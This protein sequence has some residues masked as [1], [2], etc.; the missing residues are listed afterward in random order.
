MIGPVT[1]TLLIVDDEKSTRD[2]LRTALEDKFDVYAAPDAAGK[3]GIGSAATVSAA[4]AFFAASP[5]RNAQ[6]PAAPILSDAATTAPMI[7]GR[8]ERRGRERKAG[9][10]CKGIRGAS[11]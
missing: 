11:R 5:D 2:G 8:R 7:K 4:A 3:T 1:P 10:S 6:R 9:T